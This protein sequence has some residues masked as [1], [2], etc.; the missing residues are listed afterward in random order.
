MNYYDQIFKRKSFH[1]FRNVERPISNEELSELQEFIKELKPLDASINYK[2][3]LVRED[4]TTCKR[5]GEYC[6]EFYSEEKPN[7]LRNIGYLGDQLDLWL[8]SKDIGTL[9][10]GIGKPDEKQYERLN[11]V[12]MIAIA[13]MPSTSFRKDMYKAK[14]K[15]L[16]EIWQG[17]KFPSSNVVRFAPSACNSQ[18]WIVENSDDELFIYRYKKPGK[19]GIM[20]VD[21]VCFYNRIDIGIFLLFLEIC[22][23]HDGYNFISEQFCEDIDNEAEKVLVSKYKIQKEKA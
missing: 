6:I 4:E 10:F 1:L 18:P 7:C 21:K 13:K 22:L 17:N 3:K 15:S 9:W 5:G 14:R 19:R 23:K 20:P 2:I 8:T 16:E 12:I 11:Y